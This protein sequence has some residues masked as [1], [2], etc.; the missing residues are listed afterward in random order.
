VTRLERLDELAK[1][2]GG[3]HRTPVGKRQPASRAPRELGPLAG[4]SRLERLDLPQR[5]LAPARVLQLRPP[6]RCLRLVLTVEDECFRDVVAFGD[7]EQPRP[8]VVVLALRERG[9]V[10]QAVTLEDRA[11]DEHR[12]VEEGGREERRPADCPLPGRHPVDG[13]ERPVGVQVDH[14]GADDGRARRRADTSEDPVEPAGKRDVVR[15]HP[16]DVGS[17]GCVETDVQRARKTERLGIVDDTQPRVSD[18]GERVPR[19]VV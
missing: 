11:I 4:E 16:R 14:P 15:V 9:V 3:V 7:L 6:R 13:A 8:E 17:A 19:A 5:H 12:R 1:G 18:G 10:A 2:V